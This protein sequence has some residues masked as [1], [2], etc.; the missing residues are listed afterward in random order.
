MILHPIK[1]ERR[2]IM[3]KYGSRD[4]HGRGVGVRGG[5][6]RNANTGSCPTPKTSGGSGY[7]TGGGRGGGTNR[8]GK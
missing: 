2:K 1:S 8:K 6:R 7:S 5:G 3:V 4:G